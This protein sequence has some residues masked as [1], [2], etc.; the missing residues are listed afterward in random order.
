MKRILKGLEIFS[1]YKDEGDFAAGHDQIWAGVNAD[2]MDISKED[3]KILDELGW[4]IDE[5]HDSWSH[6]C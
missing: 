4:F 3:L 5:E 6:F 1:K 2:E